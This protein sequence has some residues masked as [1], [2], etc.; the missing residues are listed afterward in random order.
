MRLTLCLA[1]GLA[2]LVLAAGAH[3]KIDVFA[4]EPEW[5][6]LAAELGGD[7]V[8]VYVASTAKQDPHRIEARPSLIARMRSAR[9][10]VC[11][12]AEL[13]IGWLPVLLKT[14]GNN[15]VQA[16]QAGYFMAADYVSKLD[17]PARVDRA[18]GDVHPLGNPHIHLDPRNFAR[19]GQALS[20]R[21]AKVD[22]QN[23]A[24]YQARWTE[25][26]ARWRKA[27]A[28]WEAKAAPLKGLKVVPYHK[29]L[30]YLFNWLGLVEVATIEPK[31]GIPPS[32]GQL[33][34]LLARLQADPAAAII[35]TAHTDPKAAEWLS[36][37]T[38]TPVV[39]LAYTVGGT[40]QAKD[41]FSLF[42]DTI[43]RLLAAR[44]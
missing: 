34:E 5:A 21:L 17:V 26:D 9:I 36:E 14:A 39:L 30:T 19:V 42:D 29:D 22:P 20:E 35:V 16:G 32:A 8:A 18:E 15:R 40:P 10:A 28:A 38:K 23:A 6:A 13:E 7:K 37:R 11:T 33:A 2:A 24:Y 12:G 43:D 4:C 27:I 44:K 41:L 31:P 1:A 25:F 3:A